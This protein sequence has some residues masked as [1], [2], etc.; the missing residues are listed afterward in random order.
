MYTFAPTGLTTQGIEYLSCYRHSGNGCYN[1]L[2]G[3]LGA[4]P[5]KDMLPNSIS[6]WEEK[7]GITLLSCGDGSGIFPQETD[8][9][10]VSRLKHQWYWIPSNLCTKLTVEFDGIKMVTAK[11]VPDT[12]VWELMITIPYKHGLPSALVRVWRFTVPLPNNT[13]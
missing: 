8:R 2:T 3:F 10:W 5:R 9:E 7:C 11:R 12:E 13:N 4:Y 6:E 1:P